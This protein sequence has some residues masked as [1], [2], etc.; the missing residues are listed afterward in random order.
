MKPEFR[1]E[2]IDYY[3]DRLAKG[4][5]FALVG[6]SDAE[7]FSILRHHLGVKT[8]LGQVLHGPTGD[9]L[10]DV[11]RRRQYY[12]DFMFAVPECIWKL[13]DFTEPAIHTNIE[14]VL[15]SYK[16]N[17]PFYERDMIL[18]D[19]ARSAELFPLISQLQKMDTVIIGPKELI[20]LKKPGVIDYSIF[21]E[22]ESPN[23]HLQYETWDIVARTISC[24]RGKPRTFLVSAGMSSALII[25]QL[26][27]KI[28]NSTFIDCGSIWDAFVG[29]GGQ[30]QWRKRLYE[31]PEAWER[32][33]RA[34]IAGKS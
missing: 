1:F 16:I 33:K 2:P 19:L 26:Y 22:V 30:R 32:W 13:P 23:Y 29:I 17:T 10:L 3:I 14:G 24:T 21:I 34:N 25:D 6:Y 5:H 28:P 18:D 9:R 12:P 8:G 11:L 20:E 15:E 7:W 27:G 4:K 31:N